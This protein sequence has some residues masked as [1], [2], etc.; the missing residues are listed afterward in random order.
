MFLTGMRLTTSTRLWIALVAIVSPSLAKTQ[1]YSG[2]GNIH[3]VF[4][5]SETESYLRY[6]D[7][8]DTT[9][10]AGWLIRLFSTRQLRQLSN[11][12]VDQPWQA[13]LKGFA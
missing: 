5:G 1:T 8:N 3:E 11:E 7:L 12:L 10:S 2:T 9:S 6:V 4:V 13:H